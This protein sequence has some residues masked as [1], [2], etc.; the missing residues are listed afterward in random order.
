MRI[1]DMIIADKA[2]SEKGFLTGAADLDMEIGGNCDFE[3]RLPLS[4]FENLE[5]T[6]GNR[7]YITGTEYGGIIADCE[8]STREDSVTLHGYTWRG[9]LT[10]R[11]IEP[12]AGSN[13]LNVSGEANELIRQITEKWFD[14]QLRAARA[15]SGFRIDNY[16]FER[17]TDGLSGLMDMLKSAGAKLE[18][19]YCQTELSGYAL[20]RAVPIYDFSEDVEY[21]NDHK[22]NFTTKD[23]RMGTN[24]LICLGKG[25]QDNQLTIHLYIDKNGNVSNE[26]YFTGIDENTEVYEVSSEENK[27]KLMQSGTKRLLE[28]KDYMELE[29]SVQDI[30]VGVGDIVGGRERTTGLYMKQPVTNKILKLDNDGYSIEYKVGE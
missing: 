24:H 28:L 18:I 29:M 7:I 23:Y 21:S 12:P 4:D 3:L 25:E 1:K 17:Y 9:L 5:Y 2:G 22:V 30:E 6:F 15:D 20:L 8:T 26:K 11:V 10:R 14:G 27:E 13:H 16:N 19:E